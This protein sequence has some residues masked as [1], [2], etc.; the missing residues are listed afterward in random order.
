MNKTHPWEYLSIDLTKHTPYIKLHVIDNLRGR[1][2]F[3]EHHSYVLVQ[4]PFKLNI[5]ENL[6][7]CRATP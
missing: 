3:P 7:F 4:I 1:L 6:N 5:Y 2:W